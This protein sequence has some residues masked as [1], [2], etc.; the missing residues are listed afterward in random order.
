[1][2]VHLEKNL[3]KFKGSNIHH[4]KIS[5]KNSQNLYSF[6]VFLSLVPPL[7]YEL[8]RAD[9]HSSVEWLETCGPILTWLVFT[10]V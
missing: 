1:M 7:T 9:L 4:T 5:F 2:W 10:P 6:T 3:S 8:A